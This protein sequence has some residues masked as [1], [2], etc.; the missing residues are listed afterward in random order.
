[1]I[2]ENDQITSEFELEAARLEKEIVN[3]EMK[4]NEI[5]NHIIDL[6]NANGGLKQMIKQEKDMTKRAKYYGAIR[7]NIELIAKMYSSYKDF[8]S[9]KFNYRKEISALTQNKNKLVNVDLPRVGSGSV[10]G[11]EELLSVFKVIAE[12]MKSTE[13]KQKLIEQVDIKDDEQY[14]L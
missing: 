13:G 8:E 4:Q 3:I 6:E 9:V 11:P 1:M 14:D 10:T 2:M 7:G 12:T 5:Q